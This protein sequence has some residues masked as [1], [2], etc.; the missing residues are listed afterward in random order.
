[1]VYPDDAPA[2]PALALSAGLE[3]AVQSAWRRR[4]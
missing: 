4:A 2:D 3:A 1:M